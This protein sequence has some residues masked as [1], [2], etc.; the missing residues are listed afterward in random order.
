MFRSVGKYWFHF[1]ILC[2]H[3]SS[4][5]NYRDVDRPRLWI[6]PYKT[7]SR[8]VFD[9][10]NNPQV[11]ELSL[12]FCKN[13]ACEMYFNS[14]NSRSLSIFTSHKLNLNKIIFACPETSGEKIEFKFNSCL[15]FGRLKNL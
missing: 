1:P 15:C 4:V 13:R 9:V 3:T 12:V 2:N 10:C 14:L 6:V 7:V 11:V 8:L 5:T